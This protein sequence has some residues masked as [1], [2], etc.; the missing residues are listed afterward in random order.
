MFK[1]NRVA[2][3]FLVL[4]WNLALAGT[5]RSSGKDGLWTL[6]VPE[7]EVLSTAK[8]SQPHLIY[9]T[10][11]NRNIVVY[12]RN[13][14]DGTQRELFEYDERVTVQMGYER[15]FGSGKPDEVALSPEGQ[16]LAYVDAQ[17]LKIY[18]ISDGTK[19]ALLLRGPIPENL[20]FAPSWSTPL[21]GIVSEGGH[22]GGLYRITLPSWSSDGRYIGFKGRDWE[23]SDEIVMEVE[24]ERLLGSAVGGEMEWSPVGALLVIASA[25]EAYGQR[26]LYLY[27]PDPK[28]QNDNALRRLD[29]KFGLSLNGMWGFSDATFSPDGQRILFVYFREEFLPR[30]DKQR[31][32]L[33]TANLDGTGFQIWDEATFILRGASG[34]NFCFLSPRFSPDGRRVFYFQEKEGRVL[35]KSHD[36]TT[37][38]KSDVAIL[39]EGWHGAWEAV[40]LYVAPRIS[41]TK[42]GLLL[43]IGGNQDG[44]RLLLLDIEKQEMVYVSTVFSPYTTFAGFVH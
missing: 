21:R 6:S 4:V 2:A 29:D 18:R 22:I 1:K 11:K 39:P 23:G 16:L 31:G 9:A 25:D 32:T 42:D 5:C 40:L 19:R 12:H 36:L 3:M 41:W 30:G 20:D 35:L 38:E 10:K 27:E 14:M 7:K 13:L 28:E 44:L 8:L 37:G 26:G 33:A 34:A 43:L 24:T 17:G 15:R